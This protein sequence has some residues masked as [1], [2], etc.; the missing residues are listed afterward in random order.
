MRYLG[1]DFG[2][3]RI[4]VAVS[5]SE[6]RIAFPKT[7]LLNKGNSRLADEFKS[8]IS[9]EK[10]SLVVVGIPLGL[11]GM[12]TKESGAVRKF[13]HWLKLVTAIPIEFE[14]EMFTTRMAEHSGVV[15]TKKD[16]ASAAIILQ[17]YLDKA[18]RS[19]L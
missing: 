1:I 18:S 6:G 14:N 9:E 8:V 11:D 19:N 3:T 5:D 10:V 15:K 16:A 12:E 7:I 17:S 2:K 4:G 13:A